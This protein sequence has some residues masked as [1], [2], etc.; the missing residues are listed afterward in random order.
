MHGARFK[1]KQ[2]ELTDHLCNCTND[3][4]LKPAA[5]RGIFSSFAEVDRCEFVYRMAKAFLL[6]FCVLMSFAIGEGFKTKGAMEQILEANMIPDNHH[7]P[8][9]KHLSFYQ[10]D[11]RLTKKQAENLKKYDDPTKG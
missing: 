1:R 8:P 4:V 9:G 6:G 2:K 10:G 7:N 3:V 11:I 5:K